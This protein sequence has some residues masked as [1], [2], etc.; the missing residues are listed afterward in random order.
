MN[1][2]FMSW[3]AAERILEMQGRTPTARDRELVEQGFSSHI[4][5]PPPVVDDGWGRDTTSLMAPAHVEGNP[6]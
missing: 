2:Y 1:E 3:E 4:L 5:Y 6:S